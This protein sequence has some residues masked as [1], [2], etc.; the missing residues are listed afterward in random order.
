ML[1]RS[2]GSCN[3]TV[4]DFSTWE[5]Q[6]IK[7]YLKNKNERVCGHFTVLQAAVKRPKHHQYLVNLYV[8][9]ESNLRVPLFKS[10]ALAVIFFCMAAVGCNRPTTGE[11]T[12]TNDSD[13][14][15]IDTIP[16]SEKIKEP[17]HLKGE[18]SAPL[19]ND[20]NK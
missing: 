8:K 2:C 17:Q 10:L 3:K 6:E 11:V 19:N 5:L 1:F 4:I 12:I 7:D 14:V 15:K 18:V 16:E 20:K 13:V 9:T